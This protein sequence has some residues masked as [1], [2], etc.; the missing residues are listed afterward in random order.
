M[1]KLAFVPGSFPGVDCSTLT[2][3]LITPFAELAHAHEACNKANQ[4]A[5]MARD[6][7]G[8]KR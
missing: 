2:G 3:R 1:S 4:T 5:L 6:I 8:E 7:P